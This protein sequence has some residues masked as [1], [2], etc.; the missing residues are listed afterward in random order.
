MMNEDYYGLEA[1]VGIRVN[2]GAWTEYAMTYQTNASGNSV[3]T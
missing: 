2:G 1:N 3:W